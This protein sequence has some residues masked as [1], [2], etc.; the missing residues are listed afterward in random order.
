MGVAVGVTVGV[1]VGVD[2]GVTVGVGTADG[3]GDCVAICVG[4]GEEHPHPQESTELGI[5]KITAN[6]KLKI[7]N[8]PIYLI[9]F[10]SKIKAGN[11][12]I[13]YT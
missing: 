12:N 5:S 10:I 3:V 7:K 2:V 13:T 11:G 8:P 9:F 6:I 1:Y 4:V